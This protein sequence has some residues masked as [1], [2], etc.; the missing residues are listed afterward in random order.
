M[1]QNKDTNKTIYLDES[2]LAFKINNDQLVTLSPKE[3]KQIPGLNSLTHN[4][5]QHFFKTPYQSANYIVNGKIN[6]TISIHPSS[7]YPGSPFDTFKAIKKYY[8]ENKI[9]VPRFYLYPSGVCNSSCHICQFHNLDRFNGKPITERF[10]KYETAK[11][12]IDSF[13]NTNSDLKTVSAIVSGDGEPTEHPEIT[14]ILNYLND[15]NIRI[16]LT[17]NLRLPKKNDTQI[18]T[19]I[20]NNISMM[21]IS[22]KGLNDVAYDQYQ[23]TRGKVEFG[24]VLNNLEKLIT[25]LE[26]SGRRKDVLLGVASLILP[27]NTES[28]QK[29]VDYFV[30]LGID[31]LYFNPVEPSYSKWGIKFTTGQQVATQNFL[32]SLTSKTNS[33]ININNDSDNKTSN[34]NFGN[35]IIR[36]P[37]ILQLNAPERNVYFDATKRTNKEVCG[38]ALWNPTIITT[39]TPSKTGARILSCRSSQNFGNPSFWFVDGW[40][41]SMT[42]TQ[43]DLLESITKKSRDVMLATSTECKE[44][45]LERQVN[46]F[47]QLITTMKKNDFEGYFLLGFNKEDLISKGKAITFEQTK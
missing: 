28:Y 27:E 41:S 13:Q 35:T 43:E 44:C 14:N 16:F 34:T 24:K 8:K 30:Q 4:P 33:T 40:N 22:I 5:I 46:M 42:Q 11:K 1:T 15:K 31:Y 9:L 3:I 45:R 12:I 37:E 21:T 47:D 6:D 29:M 32:D 26:N 2:G 39:D 25:N 23:G 19:A 10:I 36:Y 7:F 20:A 17:S 38:S 18:L